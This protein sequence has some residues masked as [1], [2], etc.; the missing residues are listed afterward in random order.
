MLDELPTGEPTENF[1]RSTLELVL[2]QDTRQQRE[3]QRTI[4]TLPFRVLAFS[5]V[6]LALFATA[7]AG[8]R[9]V[10]NQ[11][12]RQLLRDLPVIE[13]VDLFSKV[14]DIRF[15]ELLDQEGLFGDAIGGLN[16]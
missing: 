4:W 13:N 5:A 8:T 9:Y 6:P 1:T 12:Y 11:P 10:Q 16:Q 3:K 2:T 15:L 14:E 7:F